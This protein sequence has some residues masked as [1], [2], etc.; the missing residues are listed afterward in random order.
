MAFLFHKFKY[1]IISVFV[2]VLFGSCKKQIAISDQITKSWTYTHSG[3]SDTLKFLKSNEFTWTDHVNGINSKGK[4]SIKTDSTLE[5]VY[6]L[7]PINL[8]VDSVIYSVNNGNPLIVYYK[9]EKEIA[10]LTVDGLK[11]D[12]V[13][14][15]FKIKACNAEQLS[16]IDKE[17]KT[18]SFNYSNKVFEGSISFNSI[19]RGIIG[20]LVLVGILFLLSANK[21]AIPWKLVVTG[22]GIQIVFAIC[23][24]KVS[25]IAAGFDYV[26]NF[27]VLVLDF[28][29]QGSQFVFGSLLDTKTFGFVFAFQILPTILFFSALTSLFYYL[30]ILQ[31]IVYGLAWLLG[32]TMKISG[33]ENL[34]TAANIFLGQTEAP[35]MIKPFLEKMTRSEILCIMVGGMANTAG[36]VLASY[37]GFL[38]GDDPVQQLF[39]AKH[40]LA[41]SVM[42][43]PATLVISKML[44]PQTE[45]ID[46][47]LE[48]SKEKLG[49]N[50][51]EAIANGTTDGL[52]LAVN[53][54]AMLIVF[55]ALMAMV[56]YVLK[57]V[58][59]DA[60]GLNKWVYA[61]SNQ[62]YEGFTLQAI[63]GYICSPITY[64]I[65][66]CKEDMLLVGQLLGE[67]TVLNEFNAYISMSGMKA[68]NLFTEN[69]S[70]IMSTYI[71]SGFAN[72]ASI[73]IQIGGIGSLAPNKRSMLSELGIK[74]LIGGTIASLFTATIVG[75]LI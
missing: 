10:R 24:L 20:M 61:A 73:G 7:K 63:L 59:G 49:A 69:K 64:A 42:S 72:F 46:E 41:A 26:S 58:I 29:K 44:I 36:G 13:T 66:V 18:Y 22:I 51:L 8:D 14:K 37:V 9:K 5:L 65:G 39:F 31:K 40:L 38:G 56:N 19:L 74:A 12:R 34:S 28:T 43:A 17:N 32:K 71:L 2:L 47:K 52:K 30:G 33:A 23:I 57:D 50:V 45:E 35:L 67:K 6:D 11:T 55:I 53:V 21:R 68:G 15:S 16:L 60:T 4:Y 75:M 25:F 3:K 62:R 27:F 48:L 1:T 70:I 54:A